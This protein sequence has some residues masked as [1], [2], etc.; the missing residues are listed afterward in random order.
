MNHSALAYASAP[1]TGKFPSMKPLIGERKTPDVAVQSTEAI[2]PLGGEPQRAAD[3][4]RNLV[5]RSSTAAALEILEGLR[6][7]GHIERDALRLLFSRDWT[8]GVLDLFRELFSTSGCEF[9]RWLLAALPVEQKPNLV[10]QHRDFWEQL[11]LDS[12]RNYHSGGRY[13]LSVLLGFLGNEFFEEAVWAFVSDDRNRGTGSNGWDVA[14]KLLQTGSELADGPGRTQLLL[15]ALQSCE[16]DSIAVAQHIW[17]CH[18]QEDDLSSVCKGV[19]ISHLKRAMRL[20]RR[21]KLLQWHRFA[22]AIARALRQHPSQTPTTAGQ[23]LT[24]NCPD[25]LHRVQKIEP[26]DVYR[27]CLVKACTDFGAFIRI[28]PK[29]DALLHSSDIAWDANGYSP[30]ALLEH[31]QEINVVVLEVDWISGAVLVGLKQFPF[32]EWEGIVRKCFIPG[33]LVSG[34]IQAFLGSEARVSFQEGVEGVIPCSELPWSEFTYSA[35]DFLAGSPEVQ[36]IVSKLDFKGRQIYLTRRPLI[37][38]EREMAYSNWKS[39][40][41]RTGT[42]KTITD[43]CAIIDLNGVDGLLRITDMSWGRFGHPSEILMLGKE[44]DVVVLDVNKEMG[45]VRVGLKQTIPN[46]WET[47]QA[48]YFIGSKV[49]VKVFRF[50]AHGALVELEPGVEGLIHVTELSWSER[51]EKS[52]DVLRLGQEVEAVVLGINRDDQKISLGIRQLEPNPWEA[53]QAKY[54]PGTKVKGKVRNLTKR[55]AFVELEEGLHGTVHVSEISWTRKIMHQ[56]SE[57]LQIGDEIE[58]LVVAV[59]PMKNQIALSIRALDPNPWETANDIFKIGTLVI[60]TVHYA[61]RCG[62]IVQLANGFYAFIHKSEIPLEEG[63]A[64]RDTLR[65]GAEVNVRVV[66]LNCI[67]RD[68]G[69]SMK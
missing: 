1:Q 61:G 33:K 29:I 48:K 7:Q 42:V 16:R 11:L 39:G 13:R 35:P 19:E 6:T 9:A 52:S 68:I 23:N 27:G 66:S 58:A 30:A 28:E 53:A 37:N 57:V 22:L 40:A 8:C 44:I 63:R 36:V 24:R 5:E 43:S 14:L 10:Q 25:G 62:A 20:L 32:A 12:C 45:R 49:K 65:I 41:I 38:A 54:P 4:L 60:G 15:A 21:K 2:L 18:A 69:L 31:T 26:G 47:V 34:R 51:F 59:N 56:P 64:V 55:F 3:D 67:K 46:P 17:E 50:A